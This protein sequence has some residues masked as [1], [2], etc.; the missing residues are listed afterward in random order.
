MKQ[1]I[2]MTHFPHRVTSHT[3]N[4]LCHTPQNE[5]PNSRQSHT[6]EKIAA[7]FF[8]FTKN[9][10][11]W[12]SEVVRR[13]RRPWKRLKASSPQKSPRTPTSLPTTPC[14]CAAR[15]RR[16]VAN[17]ENR[18]SAPCGCCGRTKISRILHFTKMNQISVSSSASLQQKKPR[19]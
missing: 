11:N 1:Q 2:A 9:Q 16:A 5:P 4:A 13:A 8:Y 3:E 17:S 10:K 15:T 14:R 18:F 7:F 6:N 12:S 19:S